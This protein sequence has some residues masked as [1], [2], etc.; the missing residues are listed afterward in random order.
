M[1]QVRWYRWLANFD[2][3]LVP[4]VTGWDMANDGFRLRELF[5]LVYH[6]DATNLALALLIHADADVIIYP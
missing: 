5:Q 6:G 2:G 1:R 4:R 3:M